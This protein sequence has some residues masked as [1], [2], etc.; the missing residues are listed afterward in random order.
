MQ[1]SWSEIVALLVSLCSLSAAVFSA[2]AASKAASASERS[3]SE[4]TRTKDIAIHGLRRGIYEDVIRMR[5]K[6]IR[7]S[8]NIDRDAITL[9]SNCKGF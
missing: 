2:A 4:A 5:G 6:I 7:T 3:A 1:A 9:K 8:C